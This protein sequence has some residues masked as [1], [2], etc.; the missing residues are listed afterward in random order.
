VPVESFHLNLQFLGG[1]REKRLEEVKAAVRGVAKEFRPLELEVHGAGGFPTARQAS[2]VWAGVG[3][4]DVA[5]GKLAAALSARLAPLGLPPHEHAFS[6][7]VVLG[8]A[9]YPYGVASLA[10]AL[11]RA[12]CAPPVRWRAGELVLFR[13]HLAASGPRYEALMRLALIGGETPPARSPASGSSSS[14]RGQ[15][16][17]E[18]PTS[19]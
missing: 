8:R 12:S 17:C 16:R 3:G 18:T 13:S 9:R 10:G 7:H 19:P 2:V 6:A 1:V 14:A 5:P 4:G 15:A 11:W